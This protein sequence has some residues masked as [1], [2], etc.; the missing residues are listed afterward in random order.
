[1]NSRQTLCIRSFI[2]M[3]L[4]SVYALFIGCSGDKAALTQAEQVLS[5]HFDAIRRG[6]MDAAMADYA[7]EFFIQP[8]RNR[9]TWRASLARLGEFRTYNIYLRNVGDRTD[10]DGVGTQ[11]TLHC[12]TTYATASCQEGFELFRRVGATNFVITRHDFD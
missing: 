7:P 4:F 2:A 6:D 12:Q 5:R 8:K 9:E 3:L 10:S 11:V 1:M